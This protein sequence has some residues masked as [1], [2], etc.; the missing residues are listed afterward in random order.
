[1]P[2]GYQYLKKKSPEKY[3][4]KK[5]EE[6][7]RYRYGITI[8]QRDKMLDEQGGLCAICSQELSVEVKSKNKACVDHCHESNAIRGILCYQ[9]NVGLGSFKDN[10]ELFERAIKYL[11]E[12]GGTHDT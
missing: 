5:E 1:V 11:K 9:C 3:H 8:E 7:L 2:G 4:R 12:N 6:A 10:T